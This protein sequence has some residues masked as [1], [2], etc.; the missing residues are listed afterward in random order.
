MIEV[1]F[2]I[3]VNETITMA[4]WMRGARSQG[5]FPKLC[6]DVLAEGCRVQLIRPFDWDSGAKRWLVQHESVD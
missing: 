1:I 4:W 2:A 6:R 5:R 3:L